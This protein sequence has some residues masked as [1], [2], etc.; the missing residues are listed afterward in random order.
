MRNIAATLGTV[1]IISVLLGCAN[2]SSQ[3][4]TQSPGLSRA[5]VPVDPFFTEHL[6]TNALN[7]LRGD[8]PIESFRIESAKVRGDEATTRPMALHG[9]PV[10][11]VGPTLT[12][13]QARQLA[14]LLFDVRSKGVDTWC[15][16]EPGFAFVLRDARH[17]LT[18]LVCFRCDE[19]AFWLEGEHIGSDMFM[20]T[21][22]QFLALVKEIFPADG[23]LKEIEPR[24][25]YARFYEIVAL[26]GGRLDS[27][28]AM[29]IEQ[30]MRM[31]IT[32]IEPARWRDAGGSDFALQSLGNGRL[33]IAADAA[34]HA[35]FAKIQGL[36][37]EPDPFWD[38]RR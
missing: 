21:Q 18:L 36:R 34:A 38:S 6:K 32:E 3:K 4:A 7:L 11:A 9:Y 15:D 35:T 8:V 30:Q 20:D 37:S 16:F 26:T 24:K 28:R 23:A 33:I 5:D 29:E 27:D 1:G 12:P 25:T 17:T 19:C 10:I 2:G 14:T 13:A 22:S 31:K